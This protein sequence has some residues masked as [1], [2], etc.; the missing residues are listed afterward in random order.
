MYAVNP[1]RPG[2][3]KLCPKC[4]TQGE[5]LYA[6]HKGIVQEVII[7]PNLPGNLRFEDFIR[8]FRERYPDISVTIMEPETATIPAPARSFNIPSVLLALIFQ[9]VFLFLMQCG[10]L[11]SLQYAYEGIAS[12]SAFI[13]VVIGGRL[14]VRK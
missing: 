7:D 12:I 3:V 9:A 1:A 5:L 8:I 11:T 2:A 10:S 13:I 14:C 6:A 4:Q